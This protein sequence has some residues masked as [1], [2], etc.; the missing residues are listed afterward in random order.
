MEKDK[1]IAGK[2]VLYVNRGILNLKS[3]FKHKQ[4]CDGPTFTAGDSC[5]Y[6]CQF[7]FTESLGITKTLLEQEGKKHLDVVIRR[8]NAAK[9]FKAQLLDQ[10]GHPKFKDPAD[11]R[12]IYASPL[13]DVAASIELCK[14]TVEICKLILELTHWQIRLL[15]KSNLLPFIAKELEEHK[16]RLIFGVS[17]GTIDDGLTKAFEKGTPLVSKRIQSIHKLQDAGFRTFGMICP[18]LPRPAKDYQTFS[19]EVCRLLRIDKMEQIWAEVINVRGESL[20][21]TERGLLEGGFIAEAAELHKVS[22]S[23]KLWEEYNRETFLGHTQVIPPEKLRFL[24][25][26]TKDTRSWWAE[27]E[28][29]GAVLL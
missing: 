26:V 16:D 27:R 18:S 9:T 6:S 17:T 4:L 10:K 13:V 21:A 28:A 7:C 25:Y 12:V 24:S 29:L 22:K 8:S 3:A 14:E 1:N 15:S 19:A 2:P 11:T 5:V 23:H 20:N